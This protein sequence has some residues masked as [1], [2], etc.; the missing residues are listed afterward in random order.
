MRW[1][2][3]SRVRRKTASLTRS[4]SSSWTSLSVDEH[5]RHHA[6]GRRRGHDRLPAWSIFHLARAGSGSAAGPSAGSV[7]EVYADWLDER[8]DVFHARVQVA[9]L[10]PFHGCK[11][12]IDG[13]LANAVSA[14]PSKGTSLLRNSSPGSNGLRTDSRR[15]F[16]TMYQLTAS[17]ALVVVLPAQVATSP[18]TAGFGILKGI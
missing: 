14:N 6:D 7:G 3:G 8:S 9:T 17:V 12:A 11:N 5:L 2:S 10:N 13:Q 18:N 16:R 1:P 4:S 15:S